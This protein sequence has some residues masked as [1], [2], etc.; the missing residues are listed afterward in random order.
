MHK[1]KISNN[2][3]IIDYPFNSR[4]TSILEIPF[5]ENYS[6]K[7]QLSEN[8][9]EINGFIKSGMLL[10]HLKLSKVK[11]QRLYRSLESTNDR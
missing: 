5:A 4:S 2:Q 6:F 1:F 10:Y 9:K 3:N 7:G 8:G 11:K